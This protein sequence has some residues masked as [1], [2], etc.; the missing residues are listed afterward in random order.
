MYLHL[1][2]VKV[3]LNETQDISTSPFGIIGVR[4]VVSLLESLA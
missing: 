1:W 2:L 4:Y 3:I